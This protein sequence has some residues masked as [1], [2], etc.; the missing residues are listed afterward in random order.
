M[1]SP[2]RTE[3]PDARRRQ[4]AQIHIARK[5]LGLGEDEYRDLMFTVC[6]VKSAAEL[7][8]TGRLRFLAHLRKLG[9][10]GKTRPAAPSGEHNKQASYVRYLWHRLAGTGAVTDT[11]AALR[12][13]LKRTHHCE[14]EQWLNTMQARAAIEGLKAWLSRASGGK[15]E[16][17]ADG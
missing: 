10:T 11:D 6:R 4:L 3:D 15:Q 14:H 16:Q 1:T 12:A 5:E 13:W 9:F 17:R 2:A 8:W 7:D